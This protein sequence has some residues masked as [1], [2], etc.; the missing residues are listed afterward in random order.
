LVQ[1]PQAA[2]RVLEGH[3]FVVPEGGTGVVELDEVGTFIWQLV[4]HERSL[5]DV[6]ERICAEYEVEP[7][8]A[9]ADCLAFV[10]DLGRRGLI[11][12]RKEAR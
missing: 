4:E 12:I 1:N 5:E 7:E 11:A 6:V 2:W 8:R 3:A 9:R 10:E